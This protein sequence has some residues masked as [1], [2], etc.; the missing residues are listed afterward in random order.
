MITIKINKFQ[1]QIIGNLEHRFIRKLDDLL[2]YQIPGAIFMPYNNWDGRVRLLDKNLRFRYGLLDKVKKFLETYNLAY[3]IQDLRTKD[4]INTIDISK[5][6]KKLGK[7]PR[8]YQIDAANTVFNSDCGI[9]RVATGGG[10]TVISTLAIANL[11]K[12]SIFMV[13]GTDLLYQTYEFYKKI[14]GEKKVG[15]IG[16]GHCDIKEINVA[17]IWTVGCAIGLKKGKIIDDTDEIIEK[18][19]EPEKYKEIKQML[20]DTKVI[21]CDECHACAAAT[22]QEM[23]KY[24]NPDHIYGMSASPWRDDN[25]DIMIESILGNKIYDLPASTLIRQKYLVKPIIK[26]MNVPKLDEKLPKNYAYVYNKY[27]IENEVRNGLVVNAVENMVAKGYKP[28]VLYDKINHGKILNKLLSEKMPVALLSGKDSIDKR[29]K[30]KE[31]IDSGEIKCVIASKIFDLAVDIP[32]LSG[33]VLGGGGKS[34][35][36]ALQRIGRVIRPHPGKKFAAIVDFLDNAHYLKDHSK[37]RRKIYETE[38]EFDVKWPE[39][40]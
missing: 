40:A 8:Y 14:F 26:F 10:K 22:F 35:V 3:D 24:V 4:P 20:Q 12:K 13:I 38:E 29:N 5:T 17:S 33:L 28:L 16:D 1:C 36:R 27:I 21:I 18:E 39:K 19:M 11:G 34:S 31:Q 37:A 32:C 6:L 2:S 7:E 9:I 15:I 30:V 23:I 25:A